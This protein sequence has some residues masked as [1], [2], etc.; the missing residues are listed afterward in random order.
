MKVLIVK[1]TNCGSLVACVCVYSPDGAG[2]V[3]GARKELLAADDDVSVEHNVE[4]V[5][6][7]RCYC[8]NVY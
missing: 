3:A 7:Q 5:V 4:N 1:M 6:S 8:L 2:W